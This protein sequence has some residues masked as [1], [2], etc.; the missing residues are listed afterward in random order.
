MFTSADVLCCL[1]SDNCKTF[2]EHPPELDKETHTMSRCHRLLQ[3]GEDMS[4][5]FLLSSAPA[6][7][8]HS[9]FLPH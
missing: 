3:E 4:I 8:H 7:A 6:A 9:Y 2:S 5:S 1:Q